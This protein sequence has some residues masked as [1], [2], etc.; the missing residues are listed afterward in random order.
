MAQ[1]KQEDQKH[2]QTKVSVGTSITTSSN[3]TQFTLEEVIATIKSDQNLS[4]KI[5]SL[6]NITDENDRRKY[7]AQNLPYFSLGLF[8][9]NIRKNKNLISTNFMI[10]DVDKISEEKLKKLKQRLDQDKNIF[11]Y[12]LSPSGN[13][14]KVVY[15]FAEAITDPNHFNDNYLHYSEMF[16]RKYDVETDSSTQ[17]V[18]HACF[19][20]YDPDLCLNEDAETLEVIPK[21]TV[22]NEI[23]KNPKKKSKVKK[24]KKGKGDKDRKKIR[25]ST[26]VKPQ[27]EGRRHWSLITA[28]GHFITLGL[29]DKTILG[30]AL[31]LNNQNDP[32]KPESEIVKDVT[33]LIKKSERLEGDFWTINRNHLE[34]YSAKYIDFLSSRG[35]AKVYYDKSYIYVR[36]EDNIADEIIIPHINDYINNYLNELNGE[37][38]LYKEQIREELIGR[39]GKYFGDT[40]LANIKP[41]ELSVKNGNK[42]TGFIYFKKCYV[43]GKKNENPEIN[44][45]T[46]LKSP[47]WRSSIL[48]RE[49]NYVNIKYQQSEFEQ[50]LWN[51]SRNNEDRFV[52]LCS[53]LGY[54]IHGYKDK[55]NAKAIIAVDEKISDN[56]NGGSGKSLFGEAISHMKNSVR[57]DCKNFTFK[58]S[59]TFQE[60]E[61]SSEILEFNDAGQNF[62]FEKLF[63]V[64][65]DDM[66]IEYKGKTPIRVPF[67]ES[68]KILISTNY[69]IPGNGGSYER[70]MFELEFSDH[71]NPKHA[72]IDEFGHNFFEDWDTEEWNRFDN[73]MLECL[74]LFLDEGLIPYE[75]INLDRRKLFDR[76]SMEFVEY[77]ENHFIYDYECDKESVYA[78]FKRH[79]GYENDYMNKCPVKK[80]T[81]TKW[82][83]Y[84]SNH[85]NKEYRER[86]SNG[87]TYIRINK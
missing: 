54:L 8:K 26:A 6:R 56:P 67:D 11:C 38:E 64:I 52:S 9:N 39:S 12:F 55:S 74:M 86:P 24:G 2:L 63:S 80:N 82:L 85:T 31:A 65:T 20:S 42:D 13:G 32:P 44:S 45:Y 59:F 60:V 61:I 34:I 71:Y 79:I 62:N 1:T 3:L 16:E 53:A 28:V 27:E 83:K 69:T 15:R 46:T 40:M 21:K 77:M 23:K 22:P 57:V 70:R 66:H 37:M 68:P 81:F 25:L 17:D 33:K 47:I 51:V 58:P 41:I 4:K 50:F 48:D 87:L 29:D 72:P 76:T 75:K 78:D 84:F 43:V 36:I 7:K 49:F 18:S 5:T 30:L 73:F 10:I 14:Y 19:F 35:F